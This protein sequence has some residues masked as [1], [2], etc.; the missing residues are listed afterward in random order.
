M[1]ANFIEFL[2][3]T[4]DVIQATIVIFGTAVVLYNMKYSKGDRVVQSF[5]WLIL[6]VVVVYFADL[7][8][9]RTD[10]ALSAERW[11]RLEW[12]GI[13]FVPSAQFHLAD[14]LLVTTGSR[15]QRRRFLVG[16]SYAVSAATFFMVLL[17]D[18]LVADL[19]V[20]PFA[21]H[22][23]AGVLFPVF[24]VYY[25]VMT[26][27]GIITAWRAY[28]RAITTATRR[29][30]R[31][32]VIAF[33]G[34][35]IGVF[36]YLISNT[37]PDLELPVIF[38]LITIS[39]NFTV[40]VMFALLTASLVYFGTRS[41]DRVVRVRLY[42]FMARV[43]LT[44]I[45]VLLAYVLVERAGSF[46]G[47]PTDTAQAIVIVATVMLAQ[48][49]IHSFKGRLERLFQLNQEPDVRRIQ[50]LGD[51]LL[52]THD[53]HQ[54]LEIILTAACE[55]L[56]VP[57]AFVVSTTGP[58]V[59]L[60]ASVGLQ[61]AE[62]EDEDSTPRLPSADAIERQDG[63][64][65]WH[66]FWLLPLFDQR[67][68]AMLGI[69]GFTARNDTPDLSPAEWAILER[70]SS[71]AADALEDRLL[72]QGVFAAVGGILPEITALQ[73]RRGRAAYGT[74]T[75]LDEEADADPPALEVDPK[76]NKMVRDAL[77]HIWG[78]P[79]LAE[80]PL[81]NLD[82]V[83]SRVDE[84][85]GSPIRALQATLRQAIELQKPAG[86]RSLTGTEWLL[87]NILELKFVQGRKVRDVARR[88]ALSESDLY[89][90]QRVAIENVART[91]SQMAL[92]ATDEAAEETAAD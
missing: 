23:E 15:S 31:R 30:M 51:R 84:H 52:T 13:A 1:P 61:A 66:D 74:S 50:E 9:A 90:K 92:D 10:L 56:R 36:P 87:Y 45:L 79:K 38:W 83:Q 20:L 11:L 67:E 81:L 58:Q 33:L 60:E 69:M 19:V 44:G 71:Q 3:L 14:A 6:C 89:R 27:F 26:S 41:P 59:T 17:T 46:W 88:L 72:Q 37:N 32:V 64:I 76:F 42:K 5:S 91:L 55:A 12:I 85:D 39:G 86:E 49:A 63:L 65:R 80:S 40:S 7:L 82:V 2:T 53:L 21:S 28:R 18:W 47:L 22:L 43:P 73:R 78:G 54:F 25:W 4:N 24:A 68:D 29:R 35:P 48:W 62:T 75:L 34:A 77:K 57:S 70:L 8:I 16:V